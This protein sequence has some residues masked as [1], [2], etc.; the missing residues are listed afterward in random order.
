M[1]WDEIFGLD[2]GS[3]VYKSEHNR[4]SALES[5]RALALVGS[6]SVK[7]QKK[8]RLHREVTIER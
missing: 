3:S 6:C 2:F 7:P 1:S 5:W 8:I 4:L